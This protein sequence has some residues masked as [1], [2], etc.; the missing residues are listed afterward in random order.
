MDVLKTLNSSINKFNENLCNLLDC[1][2]IK[3]G[4]SSEIVNLCE[5]FQSLKSISAEQIP[6]TAGPYLWKYRAEIKAKNQDFFLKNSYTEDIKNKDT[7]GSSDMNKLIN[8]CKNLWQSMKLEEKNVCWTY[9]QTCL[10]NYAVY[11]VCCKKK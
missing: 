4:E 1:I 8:M 9:I 5:K 11:V 2:K 3:S 10:S 7:L 6:Q